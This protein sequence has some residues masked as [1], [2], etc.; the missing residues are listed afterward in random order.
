MFPRLAQMLHLIGAVRGELPPS[1]SERCSRHSALPT[2][3]DMIMK[4]TDGTLK[5]PLCVPNA[6][7]DRTCQPDRSID[8]TTAETGPITN[9]YGVAQS[10]YLSE[11]A[12][13]FSPPRAQGPTARPQAHCHKRIAEVVPLLSVFVPRSSGIQSGELPNVFSRKTDVRFA[14]LH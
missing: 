13:E 11:A 10:L 14:R 6:V 1:A 5:T 7:P 3:S 9:F 2:P 8:A 4:H 12:S